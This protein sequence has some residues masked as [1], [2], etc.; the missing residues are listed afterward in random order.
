MLLYSLLP[1]YW[2]KIILNSLPSSSS[3]LTIQF[4]RISKLL[5]SESKCYPLTLASALACADSADELRF[6]STS[7]S[8]T[9]RPPRG[10]YERELTLLIDQMSPRLGPWCLESILNSKLRIK[11]AET[12]PS[13]KI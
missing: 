1:F 9:A 11:Y 12:V 10:C 6:R 4:F 8:Q 3:E 2:D 5:P 13:F 7:E